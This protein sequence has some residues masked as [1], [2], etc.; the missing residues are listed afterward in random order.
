MRGRPDATVVVTTKDRRDELAGLLPTVLAQSAPARRAGARR[1]LHGRDRR[2]GPAQDPMVRLDRVERSLGL[3]AQRNR[4]A[5][6]V[7]T[8]I[9]VSVDD[10]ARLPSPDTVAQTLADFGHHRIA[11]VAMPYVDVRRGPEVKQRAPEDDGIWVTDT[12]VGTAHAHPPGRLPR[13]R[14]VPGR[15]RSRG[16]GAGAQP[17]P[18]RAGGGRPAGPGRPPAP[19]RVPATCRRAQ[20]APDLA[21]QLA[22]G[23]VGRPVAPPRRPGAEARGDDPGRRCARGSPV[24]DRPRDGG[25]PSPRAVGPAR[26]AP[27]AEVGLPR[28]P[29]PPSSR[30]AAA[31]R[32]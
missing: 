6:L 18:A 23:V 22:R 11:A 25:R 1:R 17:A 4:A 2:A 28:Q 5:H 26:P 19:P 30:P 27:G 31:G 9:I 32:R 29:R 14:R 21:Q 24:V 16:R 20:R 10:D 13:R 3:I 7:R 15:A 12:F 8:P